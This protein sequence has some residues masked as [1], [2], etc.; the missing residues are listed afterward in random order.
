MASEVLTVEGLRELDAK[1]KRMPAKIARGAVANGL[2]VGARV[3]LRQ[4][5]SNAKQRGGSGTLS[6]ALT[7]AR[8][9]RAK[10]DSPAYS[11][12]VRRGR[13]YQLGMRQGRRG[14]SRKANRSSMDGF[15]G[16]FVELGTKAHNIP[17]SPGRVVVWYGSGGPVFARRVRHPGATPKPF[18]GPAFNQR[19]QQ[20]LQA[21][22]TAIAQ[23]IEKEASQA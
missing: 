5:K 14:S 7:L 23:R 13:S 21:M 15:Y 18:L 2:R 12:Y 20:A 8:D 3:I 19:R 11:I 9:R 16:P 17:R 6:R 10:R 22:K 1:L 4:A